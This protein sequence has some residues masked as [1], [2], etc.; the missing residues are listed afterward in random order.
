MKI[1]III[2]SVI[3]AFFSIGLSLFIGVLPTAYPKIPHEIWVDLIWLSIVLIVVPGL[4]LLWQSFGFLKEKSLQIF[5]D[6]RIQWPIS[7]RKA[8]IP[9]GMALYVGRFFADFKKLREENFITFFL[10]LFN[11]T[12]DIIFIEGIQ[13]KIKLNEFTTYPLNID[14]DLPLKVIPHFHA[15]CQVVFQ[16][17]FTPE[18]A[19]KIIDIIEAGK[20]ISF[21]FREIKLRMHK[22]EDPSEFVTL[23]NFHGIACS[24]PESNAIL[25]S[26]A[27]FLEFRGS[28]QVTCG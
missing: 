13:G 19:S 11:H 24:R 8:M 1:Q 25:T 16:Q 23:Y 12:D 5:K 2:P 3:I 18:E 14:N 17:R 20:S 10:T 26:R 22:N 21:D 28:V 6:W 4:W 7:R 27:V 15:G 9:L